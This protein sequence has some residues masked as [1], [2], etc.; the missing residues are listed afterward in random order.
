M[1]ALRGETD[2]AGQDA[3]APSADGSGAGWDVDRPLGETVRMVG[4]AVA[5]VNSLTLDVE[6][7]AGLPQPEPG[8]RLVRVDAEVCAGD[9]TLFVDSA[10]WLGL[11]DD[12]VVHSAHMGVRDL[13]TMTLAPGACQRGDVDLA[14]PEDVGLAAV[15][16]VDHTRTTVAAWSADGEPGQA[17]PLSSGVT[18]EAAP[19]GSSSGFAD[20]GSATLHA[21]TVGAEPEDGSP[22]PRRDTTLVRIDGEV[23]ADRR[24]LVTGPLDWFAQLSDHRLVRAQRSGST[25][26]A[27]EVEPGTCDRGTV[28]FLI[29]DDG[30]LVAVIYAH[31][32]VYEE[33]RWLLDR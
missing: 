1:V 27:G 2:P 29:P 12:D 4:G 5:R 3:E 22:A 17:G 26:G 33:A 24:A 7:A 15:I 10:F 28:D 30:R 14:L 13:L 11:G 19:I 16:L 18:P 20:T 23:C 31:G 25:T 32:G 9:E 6:L 8:T 21:V